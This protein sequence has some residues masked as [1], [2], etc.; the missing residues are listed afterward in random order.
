MNQ[1]ELIRELLHK[2]VDKLVDDLDKKSVQELETT[3]ME[4]S[5]QEVEINFEPPKVIQINWF[6]TQPKAKPKSK[7]S[8]EIKVVGRW[9]KLPEEVKKE[10]RK[11]YNKEYYEKNREHR[12]EYMKQY[13]D[14]ESNRER[15]K[16]YMKTY[17]KDNKDKEAIAKEKKREYMREYMK[18]YM[19]EYRKR[20]PEKVKQF[21]LTAKAN[22][23]LKKNK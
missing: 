17:H 14:V 4:Q 2:W 18:N 7:P 9:N 22:Q 3:V 8:N 23:K 12:L 11:K 19:K 13:R 21:Y 16:E 15:H 10:K 5:K 20:K 6:N 1:L